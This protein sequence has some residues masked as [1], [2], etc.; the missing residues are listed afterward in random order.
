LL[1]VLLQQCPCPWADIRG[2]TAAASFERGAPF[3]TA[4][5]ARMVER[6]S[7]AACLG[8]KAHPHM[9]RHAC[10]FALANKGT[11][12]GRCRPYL[13]SVIGISSTWYA[14]PSYR[15]IDLGTSGGASG[16]KRDV[17][18]AVAFPTW[19]FSARRRGVL[20]ELM[21]Q[22]GW[23]SEPQTAVMRHLIRAG[24]GYLCSGNYRDE[25]ETLKDWGV[26][27][28]LEFM[29]SDAAWRLP[30]APP[31]RLRVAAQKVG[32]WRPGFWVSRA[33]S[34]LRRL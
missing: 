1:C 12:H 15:R 9:L 34:W 31:P 30:P 6:A 21:A 13:V 8:F 2:V 3:T 19:C 26:R 4:G 22:A 28:G 32:C 25:I 23:L 5:F 27:C 14:T 20:I 11:T 7:E 17:V 33:S 18:T 24:H 10:G 16:E 29:C